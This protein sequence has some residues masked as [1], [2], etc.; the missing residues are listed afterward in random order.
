MPEKW[1]RYKSNSSKR[2]WG[3]ETDGTISVTELFENLKNS[4]EDKPLFEFQRKSNPI[5]QAMID[6]L[7][8]SPIDDRGEVQC[9]AGSTSN[10]LFVY[11]PEIDLYRRI[12]L[13]N[14]GDYEVVNQ[15]GYT[16]QIVQSLGI[17]RR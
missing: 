11:D 4:V 16:K 9:D 6:D 5:T 1:H 7:L 2:S 14:D 13:S 15:S 8:T 17:V 10:S 3:F 12:L